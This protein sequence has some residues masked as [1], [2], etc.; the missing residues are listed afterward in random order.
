MV[1]L[2][3][4]FIRHIWFKN[5]T[6]FNDDGTIPDR[7]MIDRL[8]EN[9]EPNGVSIFLRLGSSPKII[10]HLCRFNIMMSSYQYRDSHYKDKRVSRQSYLHN[11]HPHTS[12]DRLYVETGPS[13]LMGPGMCCHTLFSHR[14]QLS[15]SVPLYPSVFSRVQQVIVSIWF[16]SKWHGVVWLQF[17]RSPRTCVYIDRYGYLYDSLC[18]SRYRF[19][20][21]YNNGITSDSPQ[22]QNYCKF[23][24]YR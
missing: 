23:P 9:A 12:K 22:D 16:Y 19:I 11:G 10:N 17:Y 2:G 13:S 4:G 15:A 7:E 5:W 1:A 24:R 8:W 14:C 21:S 20:C 3:I 18:T 6:T